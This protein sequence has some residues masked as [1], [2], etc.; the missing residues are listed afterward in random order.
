MGF[1]DFRLVEGFESVYFVVIL[2]YDIVLTRSALE[3]DATHSSRTRRYK[4]TRLLKER[5]GCR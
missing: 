3:R 4:E 5:L 2:V 1:M